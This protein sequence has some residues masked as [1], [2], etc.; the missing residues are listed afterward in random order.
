MSQ[1]D[2]YLKALHTLANAG[3]RKVDVATCKS[4]YD[5]MVRLKNVVKPR[6]DEDHEVIN[7]PRLLLAHAPR[8]FEKAGDCEQAYK[9]F[10]AEGGGREAR[11]RHE[12]KGPADAVRVER[13]VVQGQG[14]VLTRL[15]PRRQ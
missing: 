15:A 2:Q 6:N 4:S 7:A 8:C 5:T 14:E 9:V 13:F 10:V 1:R 3:F 11:C 12:E